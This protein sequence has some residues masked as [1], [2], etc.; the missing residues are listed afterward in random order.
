MR[1]IKIAQLKGDLGGVRIRDGSRG[2][3]ISACLCIC[4]FVISQGIKEGGAAYDRY[5]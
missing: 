1:M 5:P 3:G 4:F 2:G